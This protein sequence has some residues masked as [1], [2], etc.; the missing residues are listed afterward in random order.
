VDV[1]VDIKNTAFWNVNLFPSSGNKMEESAVLIPMKRAK[2]NHWTG[3]VSDIIS[4]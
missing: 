1:R 4:F 3:M 2:L